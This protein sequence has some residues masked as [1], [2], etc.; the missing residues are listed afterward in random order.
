MGLI[1]IK[2]HA[3]NRRIR[4]TTATLIG[5]ALAVVLTI[6]LSYDANATTTTSPVM[7]MSANGCTGNP[8]PSEGAGGVICFTIHGTGLHVDYVSSTFDWDQHEGC[9]TL[10]IT[11]SPSHSGFPFNQQTCTS[12][13]HWSSGH[14]NLNETFSNNTKMCASWGSVEKICDTIHS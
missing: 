9:R 4:Q 3:N 1:T 10:K 14:I 11:V 7:P 8:S 5:L 12:S 13:T 2:S 6:F